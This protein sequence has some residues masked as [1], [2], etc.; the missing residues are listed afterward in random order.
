MMKRIFARTLQ[1][2]FFCLTG[3]LLVGALGQS[4]IATAFARL[5]LLLFQ[6]S[7]VS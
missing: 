5:S 7:D 6:A 4:L 2:L 3:A 1:G